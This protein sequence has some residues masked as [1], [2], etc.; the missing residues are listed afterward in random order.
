MGWSSVG[1]A[2]S[3]LCPVEQFIS[4]LVFD[5]VMTIIASINE[6]KTSAFSHL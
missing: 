5:M 1:S 6:I 4:S 2:H 3:T